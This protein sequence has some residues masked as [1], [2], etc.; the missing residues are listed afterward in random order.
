[1]R[2]SGQF[3]VMDYRVRVAISD[4]LI[5]CSSMSPSFDGRSTCS[6][7]LYDVF[8][9]LFFFISPLF[10][11][12]SFIQII[13]AKCSFIIFNS[14][15]ITKVEI[16]FFSFQSSKRYRSRL[17]ACQFCFHGHVVPVN[18]SLTFFSIKCWFPGTVGSS[19]IYI[20]FV[21]SLFMFNH[22]NLKPT[23]L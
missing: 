11:Y 10:I 16:Q 9:F 4:P 3:S 19:T 8:F 23:Y 20:L 22:N 2:F 17:T 21:F 1:M 15:L 18:Y 5:C 6:F 14:T 12:F 7:K 13:I